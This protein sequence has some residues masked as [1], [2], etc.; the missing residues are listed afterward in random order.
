MYGTLR[1]EADR[2]KD[3]EYELLGLMPA[4]QKRFLTHVLSGDARRVEALHTS[5]QHNSQLR[6]L[7]GNPLMLSLIAQV[8]DRIALPATRAEFYQMAVG[9]MWNRRLAHH[10]QARFRTGQRDRVL[11]DLAQWM[12]MARIEAPLAWLEEAASH[13][14]GAGYESLIASLVQA[15]MVRLHR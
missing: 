5:L 8:A 11:T 14:A 10:L 9:E 2:Y 13:V 4:D 3:Q 6:L 7:A 12:G 1:R 15:G